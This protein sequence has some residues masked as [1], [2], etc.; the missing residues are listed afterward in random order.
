MVAV[1]NRYARSLKRPTATN[2][3]RSVESMITRDIAAL[4]IISIN[5]RR[6]RIENRIKRIPRRHP[7]NRILKDRQT[8]RLNLVIGAR[9][10]VLRVVARSIRLH[11]RITDQRLH[12]LRRRVLADRP[13][14]AAHR[15]IMGNRRTPRLDL[16][17]RRTFRR[18][19]LFNLNITRRR[20][21]IIGDVVDARMRI[22]H[23]MIIHDGD[24]RSR[25]R[26]QGGFLSGRQ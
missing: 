13:I 14:I 8:F 6:Q 26:R 17:E 10:R 18:R 24:L 1:A 5:Q 19:D 15:H 3:I 21:I 4:R 11:I 9:A 22:N 12:R 2:R 7:V 16:P 25:N 20:P 23:R